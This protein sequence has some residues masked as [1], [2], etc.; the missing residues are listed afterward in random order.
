MPTHLILRLR[1]DVAEIG[2]EI[3]LSLLR[4]HAVE[5]LRLDRLVE[6]EWRRRV[7][8][9]EMMMTMIDD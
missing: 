4:D 5:F 2:Q 9:R 3:L 8:E 7:R 1:A 6:L